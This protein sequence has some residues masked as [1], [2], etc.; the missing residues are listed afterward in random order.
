MVNKMS[1]RQIIMVLLLFQAA[2]A[3]ALAEPEQKMT[4]VIK[5]Y[6]LSKYPNF[7][8]EEIRVQYKQAASVLS[9]L[10]G[11][12]DGA[13]LRIVEY[14]ADFKPIGNVVFPVEAV[15]GEQVSK[16]FIRAKVEV[17]KKIAAA[18]KP[19]K[20][21]KLLAAEDLKFEERD[22][23]LLPQKYFLENVSLINKEARIF[24]PQ[25]STL[26][27]WMVGDPALVKKGSDVAI[28]VTSA[29][30][31][32]RARGEALEDGYKDMEI[33]VKR[34]DSSKVIRGKVISANE[35]EVKL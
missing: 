9:G 28:L 12:S 25:N 27:E 24:V 6:V 30:L 4:G 3:L 31:T 23:A 21:G 17:V 5:D 15:D 2:G 34:L 35:V 32:V 7:S 33:K 19:I 16:L 26:F 29:G 10:Q 20:K 11:L 8:A 22:I 1:F 14:Y 13:T 18:A